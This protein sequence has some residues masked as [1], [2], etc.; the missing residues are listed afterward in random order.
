MLEHKRIVEMIVVVMVRES[1]YA[2][3][4]LSSQLLLISYHARRILPT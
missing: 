3:V 4:T 2:I 1:L